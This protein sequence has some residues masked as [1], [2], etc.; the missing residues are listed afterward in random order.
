MA[1]DFSAWYASAVGVPDEHLLYVMWSHDHAPL[2]VGVATKAGLKARMA[3]HFNGTA[4]VRRDVARVST[5]A[6]KSRRA[7]LKA[8]WREIARLRPTHNRMKVP[9]GSG[10]VPAYVC[11]HPAASI[12]TTTTEPAWY[13][14]R[15]LIRVTM[16]CSDCAATFVR[17]VP[18]P[19]PALPLPPSVLDDD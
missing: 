1:K 19:R 16:T 9:N 7:A 13:R 3:Q 5:Q 17:K 10:S 6:H 18:N 2:Y 12:T 4:W 8:E 15:N 14:A 11:P